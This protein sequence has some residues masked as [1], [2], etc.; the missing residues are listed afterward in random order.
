MKPSGIF[1]V[2]APMGKGKA[3]PSSGAT[4]KSFHYLLVRSG[5]RRIRGVLFLVSSKN[6]LLLFLHVSL[7]KKKLKMGGLRL[8]N[9]GSPG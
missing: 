3:R 2:R 1:E 9:E 6:V 5:G 7:K 8:G 4:C